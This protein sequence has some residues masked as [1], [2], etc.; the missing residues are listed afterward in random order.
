MRA[1]VIGGVNV[2]M[3]AKPTGPLVVSASNPGR[4][5]I[6]PGGA[7]RNVA[8][9][10]ARLGISTVLIAAASD[11]PMTDHAL[12]QTE[13]AGVD[14]SGVVRVQGVGNYYVA[15]DAGDG[16]YAVSDMSAAEALIPGDLDARASL[17]QGADVVVID[18]NLHPSA[19]ARAA[20]LT[21][22]SPLCL[23]P[24]SPAK[25]P[26]VRGVMKQARMIVAGAPDAEALIGSHIHGD[27]EAME[28]ARRLAASRDV[29]V[30]IT[31]GQR[32]L[33]WLEPD[34]PRYYDALP[35]AV[36]DP[37]GAGD[38]VAAVVVYA[39]LRGVPSAVAARLALAAAAMTL[40][41]EG[42][43]HPGLSL[44]ALHARS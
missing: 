21:R 36:V 2:D 26:R 4:V 37:T 34:G 43:T 22:P 14:V 31:L 8:E 1:V 32:G 16:Q 17:I 44:D 10:L 20:E 18:A 40:A 27:G 28:A 3:L 30:I 6:G 38:A 33:V 24:V 35:T 29:A 11:E 9:N 13:A 25:A 23:L 7:G 42:A 12:L 41:V 19:I 5:R 15:V 39:H